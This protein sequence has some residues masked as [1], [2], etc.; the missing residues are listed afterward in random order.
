MF[1]ESEEE[2]HALFEEVLRFLHVPLLGEE[3]ANAVSR[4][5]GQLLVSRLPSE[6]EPSAE[7]RFCLLDVPG[8]DCGAPRDRECT[9]PDDDVDVAFES[10]ER[11]DPAD[12]FALPHPANP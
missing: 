6:L 2:L 12:G 3:V 5:R 1:A 9:G 4:P 10:K 8:L 11:F 7:P